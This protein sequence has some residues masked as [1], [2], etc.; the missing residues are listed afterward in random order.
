MELHDYGVI[1]LDS[2]EAADTDGGILPWLIAGAVVWMAS[3]CNDN[4]TTVQTGSKNVNINCTNCEVH[5]YS[6]SV[7]VHK[8]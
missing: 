7:T 4:T 2:S 8:R 6:D 3:S 1:E 5:V